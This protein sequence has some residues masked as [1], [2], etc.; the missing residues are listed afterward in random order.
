MDAP[1]TEP[2]VELARAFLQISELVKIY[3]VATIAPMAIALNK[4]LNFSSDMH[5]IASA[6]SLFPRAIFALMVSYPPSIIWFVWLAFGHF[7]TV[8]S[9]TTVISG[10]PTTRFGKF[11]TNRPIIVLFG[12]VLCLPLGFSSSGLGV[13]TVAYV[14]ITCWAYL[15]VAW[16]FRLIQNPRSKRLPNA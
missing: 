11:L 14:A 16:L 15:F 9:Q 2:R 3:V 10:F 4:I 6:L 5:V 12:L 8:F 13:L 7:L 1:E